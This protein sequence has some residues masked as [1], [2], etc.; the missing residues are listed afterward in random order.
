MK[1]G[2]EMK[3][4][5]VMAYANQTSLVNAILF[6]I[7]GIIL[8]TNPGG[9]VKFISYI[10]GAVLIIIGITNLLGYYRT[11]SK[12]NIEMNGKLVSGIILVVLGLISIL[13]ASLIETTLRLIIGAWIIYS[14]VIRLIE[15][16]NFKA[17]KTSFIVRLVISI[18]MI[19]CG[20]YV[21]L[22]TNL[23]FSAIGLFI[24]IYSVMEIIGYV[25]YSK[26]V[27]K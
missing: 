25:M 15:A 20:F 19:I 16:I 7:F 2:D 10:A 5:K 11:K 23:V 27:E 18:L 3:N 6:L 4:L 17:D 12:L 9:I 22:K 8:F 14:G 26:K 24:I 21:V 13:F 1:I